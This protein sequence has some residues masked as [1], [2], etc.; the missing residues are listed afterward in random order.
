MEA[1]VLINGETEA[2]IIDSGADINYANEEWCS[3]N[4]IKY[5][6]TGYGKIKAYD[7]SYV[8]DHP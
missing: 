1:T 8:Q 2:A 6:I 4:G 7:E 5:E 3:Q